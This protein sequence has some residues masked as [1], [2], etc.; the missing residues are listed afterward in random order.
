MSCTIKLSDL[1]TDRHLY[2]I[3]FS[4]IKTEHHL[5]RF[6]HENSLS[7]D[8]VNILRLR[9]DVQ[10]LAKLRVLCFTE[11]QVRKF[12]R[13]QNID[14]DS[15]A[16]KERIQE[17]SAASSCDLCNRKYA[18]QRQK[19]KHELNCEKNR[20]CESCHQIFESQFKRNSHERR[21]YMRFLSTTY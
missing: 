9:G 5:D 18:S 14:D 8:S 7:P 20:T 15:F 21:C 13:E 17:I 2:Y 10:L 19:A 3:L 16:V 4:F 11:R 1:I 12:V 6:L